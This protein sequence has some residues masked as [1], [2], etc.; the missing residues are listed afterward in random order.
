[1]GQECGIHGCAVR[2]KDSRNL[3]LHRQ[4]HRGAGASQ[5]FACTLCSADAAAAAPD[6]GKATTFATWPKLALHLW[7]AH[8]VDMELLSCRQCPDFR[9]FTRFE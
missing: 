8:R 7:R 6:S 3:D 4:S 2:L 9:S 1:M 5:L